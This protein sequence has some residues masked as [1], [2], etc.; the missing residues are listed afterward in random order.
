MICNHPGAVCRC[1]IE[2]AECRYRLGDTLP[3]L[4]VWLGAY[5][6]N[7][8]PYISH[9]QYTPHTHTLSMSSQQHQV[10]YD[11]LLLYFM[12]C[13]LL[14]LLC[15]LLATQLLATCYKIL[16][17]IHRLLCLSLVSVNVL[18]WTIWLAVSPLRGERDLIGHFYPWLACSL[19]LGRAGNKLSRSFISRVCRRDIGSLMQKS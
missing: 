3:S 7:I 10:L 1:C 12:Y 5:W 14:P 8:Q 17:A 9:P 18:M 4:Y 2:M 16:P 13:S 15:L 11:C 19:L 6:S